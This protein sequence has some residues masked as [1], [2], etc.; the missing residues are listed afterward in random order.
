VEG[1]EQ[2]DGEPNPDSAKRVEEGEAVKKRATC[3]SSRQRGLR[4]LTLTLC[5]VWEW[6]DGAWPE[7]PK[8][9]P[10]EIVDHGDFGRAD[11]AEGNVEP[12]SV[13]V[14]QQIKNAHIHKHSAATNHTE[15]DKLQE[16][17]RRK[18]EI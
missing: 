8:F 5:L 13:R 14:G 15:F 4:P 12:E 16:A 17:L 1:V 3:A 11:F 7:G 9:I 10:N 6:G 18:S 2:E